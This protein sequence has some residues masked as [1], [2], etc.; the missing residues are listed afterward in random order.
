MKKIFSAFLACILGLALSI[1]ALAADIPRIQQPILLTS[2]GQS[3]DVNTV[4]VLAKRANVPVEY[5]TFAGAADLSGKK[6]MLVCVGV[7]AKGFGAAGVNL[8][9][10]SARCAELFKAAKENGVYTILLHVG[11]AVRR[12]QMTNKL[13]E[14]AAPNADAIIIFGQGDNDG[15]FTKAAG[16]DKPLVLLPKTINLSEVLAE[17]SSK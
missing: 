8:D 7:S 16:D 6:T 14:L 10:E 15:F 12:D 1:S 3:P 17:L 9:T 4:N 13:L 5:K 2:L 11:G